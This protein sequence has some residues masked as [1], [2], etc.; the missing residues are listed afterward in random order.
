MISQP[1]AAV[2]NPAVAAIG[3]SK[4]FGGVQA[5]HDA[6]FA[7][8]RGEVHALVGENGAG[9]STLIKL[10]GGR[11]APDAGSIRIKGQTLRLAGPADGHALG[12]WTV[13]QELTL[14]PW[15]SVAENLLLGR[16]PRNHLGFIARRRLG[17]EADAMLA[18]LGIT[19]IDPLALV[20]DISLAE[21][22]I[23]EIVR[24][25]SHVPDILFLDE[26]TSS[27]VEREVAWLFEQIRR[28]RAGGTAIV[29][30]SH[31]WHEIRSIADRITVFRGGHH[32][33][34]FTRLDEDEAVTLMT[35]QRMETRYPKRPPLP[36]PVPALE[37][38]DLAGSGV[39]G[40]SFTLNKGEV[41]G[42]GGL[43]GHGHRSLFMMLF[44]AARPVAGG[45]VL[46]GRE[47]RL[48]SPR[49][50]M[51]RANGIALVPEDR[52][53]EGLLL[54]MSV[55]ENASLAIL[56][57]LTR[58]GMLR[59][60]E[61]IRR[62][63]QVVERLKVRTPGLGNPVGAL[64]GGNQQKVLVGRWLLAEPRILLFYDITR[65]VDVA[66]RHEMYDM[67]LRLAAEGHAILFYSSDAE[68]LAHLAH[69]V[70]VMREGRIAASLA[71]PGIT[72]EAI[73]AASLAA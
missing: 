22:Q 5:L 63:R 35:G 29:F 19:H 43:A 34:T 10:L 56:R 60:G 38:R 3:V 27:L 44:G 11:L 55:R 14:L 52:K 70:L 67:T 42:I 36:A 71:Q 48:R 39:N 57:R 20:E 28:L 49:D 53:T 72:A 25:I 16:E 68:E 18:R 65:G 15:M 8:A 50:A 54:A 59:Q 33:G 9:K 4:A 51:R 17:A 31:R 61:E 45:I 46:E 26:P 47:V 32:V 2:A 23:V 64:S 41:L 62:A 12:A 1:A 13:F 24:A 73:V 6:D 58:F 37:A 40:V 66:T 21:R 7:A 30:T 69:R